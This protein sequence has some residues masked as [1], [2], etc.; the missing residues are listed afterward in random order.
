MI[1]SFFSINR[2]QLFKLSDI[3][4]SIVSLL[5]IDDYVCYADGIAKEIITSFKKQYQEDSLQEL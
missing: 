4:V 1:S 3:L 5:F 2:V